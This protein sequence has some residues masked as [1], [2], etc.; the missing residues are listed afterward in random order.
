[1]MMRRTTVS[2]LVLAL[3]H[4][5]VFACVFG[6]GAVTGSLSAAAK[7]VRPA[8]GELSRT[9]RYRFE[10]RNTT[11]RVLDAARFWTF[12]PVERTGTSRALDVQVSHP[13]TVIDDA[14][15]NQVLEIDAGRLPPHG[16]VV[17]TVTATLGVSEDATRQRLRRGADLLAA[18]PLAEVEDADIAALA[19]ELRRPA[20]RQ[21]AEA[22][23][24]WIVRSVDDSGFAAREQSATRVLA[25]RRGDC[26]DMAWLFVALARAAGVPA[27]YLGGWVVEGNA[28]LTPEG[29]HNW[30][31]FHDGDGWRV[32][33]PQGRVF[34]DRPGRYVGF[35]LGGATTDTPLAGY[36]RFRSGTE[37]L[38]V[39]MLGRR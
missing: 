4:V 31:E 12:A 39:R 23:Y 10:L 26:S 9:L 25:S 20:A 27:R 19:Q 28:L 8:G 29:F 16:L 11:D 30:A 6:G 34:D 1:M 36:H 18:G 2:A 37:G 3:V 24:Q 17:V 35:N 7:S 33:D 14:R 21:T 13:V 22:I 38:E 5:L 32:A 15:G